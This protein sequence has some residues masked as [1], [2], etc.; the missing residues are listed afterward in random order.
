M[1]APATTYVYRR[2]QHGIF[3]EVYF[4][5]RVAA[6]GT[7]FSA[8]QEGHEEGIVK[9][10]LTVHAEELLEEIKE[11]QQMFDPHQCD[12]KPKKRQVPPSSDEARERIA[13]YKSPFYGWS[14]YV[15]DG[16]FWSKK[17]GQMEK[18]VEEA[19]QVIRIMFL[20]TSSFNE[21]AQAAG[22]QDVLRAMVFQA[23]TRQVLIAQKTLWDKAEQTKFIKRY[24]PW[25]KDKLSFVKQHF[26][27]VAKEVAKWMDDCW[28]FMFGYLVRQFADR[29][30]SVGYPEEEIWVSNFFNLTV[31]VMQEVKRQ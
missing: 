17:E 8:L 9:E 26:V 13:M 11:Y 7:V 2:G 30:L 5:R 15:A 12:E 6:Q 14:N 28:L 3:S 19:T 18:M 22:C 16:V 10:Y 4:P 24:E 23:I 31:N 29:L 20:F 25:A 27:P 1:P 21:Q